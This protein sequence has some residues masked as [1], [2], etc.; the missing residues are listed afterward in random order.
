MLSGWWYDESDWLQ[1][2]DRLMYTDLVILPLQNRWEPPLIEFF[3]GIFSG[4]YCVSC[5]SSV[6]DPRLLIRKQSMGARNRVGI[7]L[8]FWPAR[9]HC[10]AELVPCNRFLGS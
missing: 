6:P 1:V 10:L 9:L 5:S 8:S 7:G 4:F 3:L 2:L